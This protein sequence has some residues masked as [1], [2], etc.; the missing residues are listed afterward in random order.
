MP[1]WTKQACKELKADVHTDSCFTLK[2]QNQR[3]KDASSKR[4]IHNDRKLIKRLDLFVIYLCLPIQI[5]VDLTFFF[6]KMY[7]NPV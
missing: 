6:S 5:L 2:W 3:Q 7:T 4:E 1:E